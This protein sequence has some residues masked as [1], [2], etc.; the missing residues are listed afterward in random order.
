MITVEEKMKEGL[1]EK[2]EEELEEK[3]NQVFSPFYI[4]SSLRHYT[5]QLPAYFIKTKQ[6]RSVPR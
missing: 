1:E 4:I 3:V 5:L 2:V 6:L